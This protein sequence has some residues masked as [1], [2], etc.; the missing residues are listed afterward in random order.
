MENKVSPEQ[1][2]LERARRLEHQALAQVYDLYSP[3]LYRYSM[4]IL[5]DSTQAEDCVAETFSRFLH[6]MHRH[7]G[8]RR[9]FTG[10]SLPDSPQLDSGSIP[11]WLIP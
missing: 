2:L 8:P 7:K 9:T 4:R 5:G 1:D 11:S 6:A 3:G 10:L